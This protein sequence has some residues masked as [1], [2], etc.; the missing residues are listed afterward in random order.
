[1]KAL[2]A[3]GSCA[4]KAEEA[5]FSTFHV[6][7]GSSMSLLLGTPAAGSAAQPLRQ[8]AQ[9]VFPPGTWAGSGKCDEVVTQPQNCLLPSSQPPLAIV[10]MEVVIELTKLLKAEMEH[11]EKD[12]KP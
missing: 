4:Y 5:P 8:L 9:L 6:T 2:E 12:S 1:M 10:W 7:P 11:V 3:K